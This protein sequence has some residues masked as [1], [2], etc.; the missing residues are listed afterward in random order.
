MP[1]GHVHTAVTLSIG[2]IGTGVC[3]YSGVDIGTSLLFSSGCLIQIFMSPD[4]DVDDGFYGFYLVR[5]GLGRTVA[6]FYR[7]FWFFYALEVPHR[8]LLSHGLVI[9]TVCRLLYLFAGIYLFVL[10]PLQLVGVQIPPLREMFT[11][12]FPSMIGVLVC[13]VAHSLL[14]IFV[15]DVKK[16]RRRF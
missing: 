10:G 9:G 2:V 4:L 5:R 1:G 6:N 8:D 13:D 15:S 12:M 16:T 14:D 11:F 3:V 7:A